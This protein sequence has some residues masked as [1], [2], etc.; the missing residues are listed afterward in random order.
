MN[1]PRFYE[2]DTVTVVECDICEAY[3]PVIVWDNTR[4]GAWEQ[5]AY[6]CRECAE[7]HSAMHGNS[8]DR[9]ATNAL[10][11]IITLGVL[12]IVGALAAMFF[13]PATLIHQVVILTGAG[14]IAGACGVAAFA[15]LKQNGI[16]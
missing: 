13:T 3:N 9:G 16:S 5:E 7:H 11:S 12:L 15:W 8:Y 10:T 14:L 2:V 1:D 4:T 6:D